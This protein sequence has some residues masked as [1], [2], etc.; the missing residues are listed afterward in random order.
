[1]GDRQDLIAVKR[2]SYT[3]RAL[4]RTVRL[5]MNDMTRAAPLRCRFVADFLWHIKHE[6]YRGAFSQGQIRCKTNP[7]RRNIQ[8]LRPL[9][10]RGRS[11]NPDTDWDFEAQSFAKPPFGSSHGS[12]TSPLENKG[13]AKPIWMAKEILYSGYGYSPESGTK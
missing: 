3:K 4:R 13:D 1:M 11:Q 9:L 5:D 6:M 2:H 12:T 7:S 10:W 8:R